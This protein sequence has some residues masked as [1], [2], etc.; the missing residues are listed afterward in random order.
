MLLQ[1]KIDTGERDNTEVA[2]ALA[3]LAGISLNE[4]NGDDNPPAS[5]PS[6]KD[7]L[8]ESSN[9][10]DDNGNNG[11]GGDNPIDPSRPTTLCRVCSVKLK[12]TT[13]PIRR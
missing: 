8:S 6:N 11:D 12:D 9:K 7:H 10:D 5:D 3:A 1:N 4:Q 13:L 2:L